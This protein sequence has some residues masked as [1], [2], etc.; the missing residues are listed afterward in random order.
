QRLKSFYLESIVPKLKEQF[1]YKN[2]HQIPKIKKIVIN[3]GLDESSQN[4]KI[5]EV[6]YTEIKNIS[7]QAPITSKSKKA[8]ANFKLKENMSIGMFVTL[9]GEIM[10]SFLDRL[11]NLA[12]PRIRDFQG[13]SPKS[14]DSLGNFSIGLNEQLMFPEIEFDKVSKIEGMDICIVTT[15]KNK[16]EA[17]FLLKLLGM[18]F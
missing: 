15:A 1:K 6:L 13:L 9:R 18:P 12:L 16:E 14:F 17:L 4:S 5:L 10:Y 3:R 2:I 11:I 7:G 8:I